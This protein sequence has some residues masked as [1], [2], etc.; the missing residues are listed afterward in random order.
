MCFVYFQTWLFDVGH[1]A[2]YLTS[3]NG[4]FRWQLDTIVNSSLYKV[5]LAIGISVC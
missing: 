5:Y 1:N 3:N 2:H 4:K